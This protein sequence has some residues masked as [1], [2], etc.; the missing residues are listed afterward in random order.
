MDIKQASQGAGIRLD[1]V[2]S[3]VEELGQ[4]QLDEQQAGD[5]GIDTK[6]SEMD[7]VTRVDKESE[8]R[9]SAW[10][11]EHYPEDGILG[12]EGTH[13]NPDADFQWVVDPVDG[14]N[15]YAQN[16]PIFGISVGIKYQN[17]GV[18]G[19][20]HIPALREWFI[21]VKGEG[22]TLNGRPIRVGDK[23]ELIHSLACTGFPYDK[24]TNPRN[25]L[26]EISA[27]IPQVRGMRRTGCAA[28]DLCCVACGRFDFF[29]EMSLKE[30]DIAAA[31]VILEEAGAVW[32][33]YQEERPISIAVANETLLQKLIPILTD[34]SL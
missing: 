21:G 31:C 27:L 34:S 14:T 16:F 3:L 12:E 18:G 32:K 11:V 20:V 10:I 2:R 9:I 6:S 17:Q 19:M 26:R 24:G 1:G 23:T 5:L 8:R 15:N 7:L 25:N 29:W 4:Y 13:I 22:A 33:I 30:W 28:F